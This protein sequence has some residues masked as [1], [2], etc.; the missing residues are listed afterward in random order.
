MRPG[1]FSK[2]LVLLACV[3]P[4]GSLHAETLNYDPFG[5]VEIYRPKS[6]PACTVILVSGAQGWKGEAAETGARISKEAGC[7]VAGVDLPRWE[8][9]LENE[10]MFCPSGD[11]ARLSL[12]MQ[13]VLK[14]E[15]YIPPVLVGL[16]EGSVPVYAALVQTP[17]NSLGGIAFD[18]CP[19]FP[20]VPRSCFERDF[21]FVRSGDGRVSFL[22][23]AAMED[24]LFVFQGGS[25]AGCSVSSIG[26]YLQKIPAARFQP[27]PH[28]WMPAFR[29]AVSELLMRLPAAPAVAPA[30]DLPLVELPSSG[31]RDILIVVLSGDGGWVDL[32]R[33]VADELASRKYAVL[34]FDTLRYFWNLQ[35]ARKASGDLDRIITSYLTAWKKKKALLIG[36]SWG[37]DV[38]P[39]MVRDLPETSRRALL[40]VALIGPSTKTEFE[41]N[42]AELERDSEPT[43]ERLLPALKRLAPFPVL[44]L[45]GMNERESACRAFERSGEQL[46][47]MKVMMVEGGHMFGRERGELVDLILR[48]FGV[49]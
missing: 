38:L 10:K 36:Y 18:F 1:L 42:V 5:S 21:R 39:F 25:P 23:Y 31:E 12:Y 28:D 22:P 34:G 41:F 2:L 3:L 47:N 32:S 46:P 8:Q 44:C 9:V 11:L 30:G 6:I 27:R 43:G 4:G 17:Y 37:A 48:H 33:D 16:G 7:L 19:D 20:A 14:C 26:E 49:E 24:P 15:R 13:K 35:S 40:G 45:G 29:K